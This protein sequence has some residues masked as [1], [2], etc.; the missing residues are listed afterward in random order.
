MIAGE[1]YSTVALLGAPLP[2]NFMIVWER[3]PYC[4]GAASLLPGSGISSSGLQLAQR[5][6][7]REEWGEDKRVGPTVDW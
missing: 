4:R 6:K 2:D 3:H 7:W 1:R 5:C